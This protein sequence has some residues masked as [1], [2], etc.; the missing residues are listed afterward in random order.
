MIGKSILHFK[1][2]EPMWIIWNRMLEQG[3]PIHIDVLSRTIVL[4]H[5]TTEREAIQFLFENNL[6]GMA[7]VS[8]PN[9]P[10]TVRAPNMPFSKLPSASEQFVSRVIVTIF[11]VIVALLFVIFLA[12][13]GTTVL[14]PETLAEKREEL[15]IRCISTARADY[16]K[17]TERREVTAEISACRDLALSV[18][19]ERS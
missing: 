3:R 14:F 7:T 2:L 6:S 4:E 15:A 17:E 13:W 11:C 19:P 16:R 18:Y 10:R 1:T 8:I 9:P 12:L 5:V